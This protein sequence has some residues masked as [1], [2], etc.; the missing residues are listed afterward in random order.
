MIQNIYYIFRYEQ[1]IQ[2]EDGT[3]YALNNFNPMFMQNFG[4]VFL[5]KMQSP[6]EELSSKTNLLTVG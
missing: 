5:T 1:L 3:E 4:V 2:K 6:P